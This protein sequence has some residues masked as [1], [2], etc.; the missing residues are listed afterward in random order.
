[1]YTPGMESYFDRRVFFSQ[2]PTGVVVPRSYAVVVVVVVPLLFLFPS[3]HTHTGSTPNYKVSGSANPFLF[4]KWIVFIFLFIVFGFDF[5]LLTLPC[6]R[7]SFTPYF[8][9]NVL[10][11][12]RAGYITK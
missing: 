12:V 2:H 10:T 6:F 8:I 9:F 5:Q 11:R 7:V 3:L 4:L 1:M